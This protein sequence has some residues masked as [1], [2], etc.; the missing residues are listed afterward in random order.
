MANEPWLHRKIAERGERGYNV[1]CRIK[2]RV[3][4]ALFAAGLVGCAPHNEQII[5]QVQADA[6]QACKFEPDA[7]PI[8][9]LIPVF[10]GVASSIADAICNA[11]NTTPLPA[12]PGA[13]VAVTVRG[14]PVTGV[15]VQ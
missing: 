5:E 9:D 2:K 15:K 12:A 4:S 6:K 13:Q 7:K 3:V 11:V 1:R 8:V 14:I 10:G